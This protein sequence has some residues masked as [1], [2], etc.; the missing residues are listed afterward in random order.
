MKGGSLHYQK[1]GLTGS[2]SSSFWFS[3]LLRVRSSGSQT[4]LYAEFLNPFFFFKFIKLVHIQKPLVIY[5]IYSLNSVIYVLRPAPS[6]STLS[7][8]L[9]SHLLIGE[10][11]SSKIFLLMLL[12]QMKYLILPLILA[13]II[14]SF[15]SPL[16]LY[17]FNFNSTSSSPFSSVAQ[18]NPSLTLI[19]HLYSIWGHFILKC[20]ILH[21]S[22]LYILFLLWHC[23]LLEY[24][25]FSEH[26]VQN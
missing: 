22:L 2:P 23:K 16:L 14:S 5:V 13:H 10:V 6:G 26:V 7:R 4:L 12:P 25:Y 8:F 17:K 24:S 18:S 20:Y 15:P 19:F 11:C 1:V 9:S 3:I 21:S